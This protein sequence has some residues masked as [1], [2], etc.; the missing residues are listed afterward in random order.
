MLNDDIEELFNESD[1]IELDIPSLAFW[2][3]RIHNTTM[4]EME[5]DGYLEEVENPLTRERLEEI[6]LRLIQ[7]AD[8]SE[9]FRWTQ[10][11]ISKHLKWIQHENR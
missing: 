9:P 10:T 6:N 3:T 7:S 11:G 1:I 2:R 8:R 4:T 5:K